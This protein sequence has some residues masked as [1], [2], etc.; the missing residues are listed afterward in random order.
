VHA[1][2][3]RLSSLTLD[4][5]FPPRCFGCDKENTF[6][7]EHCY[8]ELPRLE[9]PYCRLCSQPLEGEMC[10]RCRVRPPAIDGIR[11]PF[12]MR[13]SIRRAVL[14]LKYNNLRALAPTLGALL[15]DFVKEMNIQA[16]VV[17]PVPLHR[18]RLAE[19]GYNQAGLLAKELAKVTSLRTLN[20]LERVRSSPPQARALTSD[21]RRVNVHNAFVLG[22]ESVRGL[23]VLLL[24]DVCTTGATLGAAA[25][26]LTEAGA[27]SVWGLTL[28]R[29]P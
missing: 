18:K 1:S 3:Q 27:A 28:A 17:V 12:L 7:C 8:A 5:L 24:D 15:A 2:L 20:A 4:L 26:V 19:R 22:G 29:E 6:L 11:A 13:D 25:Q 10:G 23:R 16:D 14:R 21:Q 9:P